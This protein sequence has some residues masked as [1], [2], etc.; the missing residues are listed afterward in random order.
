[1]R[2]QLKRLACLS[3]IIILPLFFIFTFVSK[4]FSQGANLASS[5]FS[6]LNTILNSVGSVGDETIL[7]I[8]RASV[9]PT[10]KNS[11]L[12]ALKTIIT[13]TDPQLELFTIFH[14]RF[15]SNT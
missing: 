3:V 8:S 13:D 12:S 2:K 10:E 6:Y 14:S 9:I 5:T 11:I 7:L 15:S 1:M 4:S